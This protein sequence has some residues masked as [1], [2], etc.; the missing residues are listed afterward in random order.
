MTRD[1]EI[2]RILTPEEM[3][4]ALAIRHEVF[5]RE[6]GIPAE[7][8]FDGKD[9]QA[10]HVLVYSAG[11][12]VATGR[13]LIADGGQAV[14]ARIAVLSDYRGHGLGHIVVREL[15]AIAVEAGAT[16]FSLLPHRY[17]ERFYQGLGYTTV[18]GTDSVG[19]H[20]LI[21]MTKHADG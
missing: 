10:H 13:V 21:T 11:R 9:Q 3:E 8:D 14:L 16:S 5:V 17:L 20:E 1:T 18:P 12:G 2:K 15:E 7:L 6:Q 4:S 19:G